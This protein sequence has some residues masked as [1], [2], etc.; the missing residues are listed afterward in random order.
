MSAR[1]EAFVG[2]FCGRWMPRRKT[3]C[4]RGAGHGGG[5]ATPEAMARARERWTVRAQ[6]APHAERVSPDAKRRWNQAHRLARYGLTP[7][8]FAAL[9]EA[10][11]NACAMCHEPFENGQQVCIDHDHACCPYEKVSCGRCVRGLLHP[12]CNTALGI[13]EQKLATAQAYLAA[14]P[15]KGVGLAT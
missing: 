4:A 7:E 5:C 13:I 8:R 1:A 6:S 12:R 2:E 11:G 9:M 10:Q 3:H 15:A 14:P